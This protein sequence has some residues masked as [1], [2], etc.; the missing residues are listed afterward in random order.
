M[1]GWPSHAVPDVTARRAVRQSTFRRQDHFPGV[2]RD[3]ACCP[4][5]PAS[6]DLG[7]CAP[8]GTRTPNPLNT[9]YETA[10]REAV[11]LDLDGE[12]MERISDLFPPS[13]VA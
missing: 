11:V 3:S 9:G 10:V 5:A 12:I 4:A 2:I 13:A 7:L 1:V 6:S 8:S